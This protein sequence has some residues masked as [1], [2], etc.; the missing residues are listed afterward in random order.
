M[1]AACLCAREVTVTVLATTD[2]HGKHLSVRLPQRHAAQRGLAKLGTLIQQERKTA[3][4]RAVVD[5]GDT[6]QGAQLESVYQQYVPP[7]SCRWAF[8][9]RQRL[10]QGPDDAGMNYLR[11]D[12]WPLAITSS[13]TG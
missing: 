1:F 9:S 12:A 10:R 5:C 4:E 8:S 6:I 2:M 3:P 7:V 13:T 11:Y